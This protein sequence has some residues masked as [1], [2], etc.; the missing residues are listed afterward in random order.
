M[1]PYVR[2]FIYAPA[3]FPE[4]G[5]FPWLAFLFRRARFLSARLDI[6]SL[7]FFSAQRRLDEVSAEFRQPAAGARVLDER[8]RL[9]QA[10]PS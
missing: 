6:A 7:S 8:R 10:Q 1:S 3:R 4:A 5:R 2:F 9:S